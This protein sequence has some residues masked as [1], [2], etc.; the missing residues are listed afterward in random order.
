MITNWLEI[1]NQVAKELNLPEEEVKK[2]ILS[3]TL[4]LRQE[5]IELNNLELYLFGLGILRVRYSKIIEFRNRLR[6][7]IEGLIERGYKADSPQ[8]IKNQIKLDKLDALYDKQ[9]LIYKQRKS[10]LR[11]EKRK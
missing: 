5:A 1:C 8:V 3:Y 6:K 11:A 10:N 9:K 2:E 4:D 7:R